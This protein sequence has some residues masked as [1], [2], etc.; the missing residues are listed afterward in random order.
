L[1]IILF[2]PPGAGKGTQSKLLVERNSMCQISTGDLLRESI[3]SGHPLGLSAKSFIDSGQLVPDDVVIGMVE[4][5]LRSLSGKSFILDGFPRTILQAEALRE[6][7]GQKQL[8]IGRSVFIEIPQSELVNRLT[9]RRVCLNCGAVFHVV[10]KAPRAEGVCDLC[11][12]QLVQRSDDKEDVI[13]KR[14][15]AYE[16]STEP[17][18]VYFK[19][20]GL[21]AEIDGSGSAEDVYKRLIAVI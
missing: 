17:L 7:L 4:V 11:S 16:V 15:I 13:R 6:L 3:R 14:L 18:K 2:G 21:L 9:G 20:S 5:A 10:S 1:N 19:S 8:S 12:G